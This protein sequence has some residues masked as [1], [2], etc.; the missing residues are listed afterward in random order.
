MLI[1]FHRSLR[2]FCALYF[3]TKGIFVRKGKATLKFT[4]RLSCGVPLLYRLGLL[5]IISIILLEP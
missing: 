1:K 3:E 5:L 2:K 4:Y